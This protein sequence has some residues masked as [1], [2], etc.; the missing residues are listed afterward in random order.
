MLRAWVKKLFR[1]KNPT[2]MPDKNDQIQFH[3]SSTGRLFIKEEEFFKTSKV[4]RLIQQLL[5]SSIYKD[6]K[7]GKNQPRVS[8]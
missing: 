6:L 3:A 5:D 1:L 7:K 8:H 2:V 4:K